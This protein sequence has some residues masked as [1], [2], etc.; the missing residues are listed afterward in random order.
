MTMP[1]ICAKCGTHCTRLL[2]A[3]AVCT[4]CFIEGWGR[5]PDMPLP[6]VKSEIVKLIKPMNPVYSDRMAKA[7][8]AKV[9]KRSVK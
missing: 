1:Y 4:K 7:R 2:P 6:E 3:G 8:A 9:A 5:L